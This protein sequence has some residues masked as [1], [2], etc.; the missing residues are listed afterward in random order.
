MQNIGNCHFFCK[1]L[2]PKLYQNIAIGKRLKLRT[3]E[4]KRLRY[5]ACALIGPVGPGLAVLADPC[6]DPSLPHAAVLFLP[7]DTP[8]DDNL[9]ELFRRAVEDLTDQENPDPLEHIL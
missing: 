1:A 5:H 3:A 4:G 8:L 6:R 2:Y 9:E 7:R